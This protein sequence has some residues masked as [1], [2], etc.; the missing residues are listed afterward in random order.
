MKYGSGKA[1]IR[2]QLV[3]I[4]IL[5]VLL[6]AILLTGPE[7]AFGWLQSNRHVTG[8]SNE[9]YAVNQ[10]F[11]NNIAEFATNSDEEFNAAVSN[12]FQ[13]SSSS[14]VETVI[15]GDEI[16]YS[17][18]ARIRNEDL[19]NG[20]FEYL[21]EL[22]ITGEAREDAPEGTGDY[23]SFLQNCRIEA[24]RARFIVLRKTGEAFTHIKYYSDAS[25]GG[26]L[27]Q[28]GEEI[29]DDGDISFSYFD[30]NGGTSP[31]FSNSYVESF[32]PDG[33]D[34]SI[35]ATL[36]VTIPDL[37]GIVPIVQEEGE[38]YVYIMIFVP[39]WYVDTETNQNHEMNSVLK[40]NGC[41][42]IAQS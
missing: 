20:V 7:K 37:A 40:I 15:P 34:E 25:E 8:S 28:R 18:Y 16:F 23:L 38:D 4:A 11:A 17:F 41:T 39:I 33:T 27:K 13:S 2:G 26:T 3:V 30:Y 36:T 1:G 24:N 6:V 19:V 22:N 14:H 35:G 42:I 5:S 10:G 31:S 29:L 12:I 9:I 32:C 21:V